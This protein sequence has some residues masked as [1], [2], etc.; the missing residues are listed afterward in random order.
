MTPREKLEAAF[1]P[2]GAREFGA[3]ID[4]EGLFI[5]DHWDELTAAPWWDRFS[6]DPD[7]QVAW[8]RDALR[9]VNQDWFAVDPVEAADARAALSL[10]TG[11][12]G[13]FRVNS[14]TGERTPLRRPA[15][16]G[17]IPGGGVH[18][19]HSGAC[20][21]TF[22]Q[23][24]ALFPPSEQFDRVAFMESGR[25]DLALRLIRDEPDRMPW[26]YAVSPLWRLDGPLG[27]ESFMTLMADR[28]DLIERALEPALEASLNQVR[29]RAA[30][31][32][33]A[34]WIEECMTDMIH[35]ALF[36]RLNVPALRRLCD[37]IRA[38]GMVSVYYYCGNMA[39]RLDSILDCGADAVSFE[40]SK[41]GFRIDIEDVVGA[42][43]GRCAVL[44]NLDAIGLLEHASEADLRAELRR[45]A[46][47]GRRNGS[48]FIFSLGSPVT[49]GTPATRVRLYTDLA[50]EE[51]LSR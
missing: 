32:A 29:L 50:H 26:G 17:W 23:M 18:S 38:L 20:P 13:V 44:G 6:P 34:I 9:T 49:P 21:S 35:P 41:K 5:R 28:P 15:V 31:G 51:G 16:S 37:E 33:R 45:Q 43:N 10:E 24:D 11:P 7:R 12:E 47:A 42:V 3:V 27:F 4:Y 1:S 48:R 46:K 36:A 8:R 14:R 25:A 22:A 40:E 19:N 30:L 2:E 39:D